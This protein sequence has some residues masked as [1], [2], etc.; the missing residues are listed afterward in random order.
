MRRRAGAER[1]GPRGVTRAAEW[2][3]GLLCQLALV[4]TRSWEVRLHPQQEALVRTLDPYEVV[5]GHRA[6][7]SVPAGPPLQP[8]EAPE[9]P[10]RRT[11]YRM[12]AY[13]QLFQLHL[14][15]DTAFL[16]A[17]Y[18]EEHPCGSGA[19]RRPRTCAAASTAA[20]STRSGRARPS[21]ASAG[22]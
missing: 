1:R 4:V 14:R 21:S 15:A 3:P 7:L 13:G 20:R 2:L 5:A 19:R 18:A 6:G 16:A 10:P 11:H 12:R 17:G 8:Q 9:P 22:A